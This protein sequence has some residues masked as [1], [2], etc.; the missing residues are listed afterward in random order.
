MVNSINKIAATLM[1]GVAVS[2]GAG[3]AL[4][5]QKTTIKFGWASSDN[6]TDPNAITAHEFKKAVEA[7]SNGRIEVQLFPNRQ[8]GDEKPMMEGMRL[9]TVDP[10][11]I[12]NSSIAQ[13][14]P[15]FQIADL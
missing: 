7:A 9:G 12:T 2:F 3:P 6:A 10:A 11:T 15:S 5:Q 8:L 1:L 4:A 14:E 13:T